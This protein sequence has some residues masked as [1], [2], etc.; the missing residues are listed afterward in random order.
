MTPMDG[1]DWKFCVS[2]AGGFVLTLW[3]FGCLKPARRW[4]DVGS[5][6]SQ[7]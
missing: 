3:W 7:G 6:G 2:L 1:V 4:R 5:N